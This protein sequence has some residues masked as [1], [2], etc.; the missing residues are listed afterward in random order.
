MNIHKITPHTGDIAPNAA[1]LAALA[2]EIWQEHYTPIIGAEQVE[3]MLEKFQSAEKIAADI[4]AETCIYFTAEN[5]ETGALVGYSAVEPRADCL[6]LSKLYIHS[7][8][9]GKGIAHKFLAE[10]VAIAKAQGQSRIRLTVN[11]HNAGA[12]AAYQKMRFKIIDSVKNDI[13]G[14][15]FMDD[16][17]M[18][19]E[20]ENIG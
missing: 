2:R 6:F 4:T 17:V 14:G 16:Y 8:S 7:D 13:G 15:F 3:Y 12:I 1:T 19:R 18:E 5:A 20:I 10:I 9:R 11:K